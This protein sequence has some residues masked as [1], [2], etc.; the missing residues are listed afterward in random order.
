MDDPVVV[1]SGVR[2][3][4]GRFGGALKDVPAHEL[5]ATC[6]CEALARAGV[7]PG[8]VEEVVMGEVGQVG[9]DAYN[10]RRVAL[11]AGI[12]AGATAMNVNRLCSSGLQA[13]V[14]GAMELLTGQADV[15]VAGGNESMSRLPFLDYHARDGYRLGSHELVDGTLA[16]LTDP[17]GNCLMGVTG[18]RVA[19]RYGVARE[20][21]DRFAARSQQRAQRAIDE[22]RFDEQIVPVTPPR[23]EAPVARDEHPRRDVTVEQLAKLRP[24]FEAGG[25]ATAGNASGI[26]DGAA[27]VVLMRESEA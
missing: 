25:T 8:E 9:P 7:E 2:T 27:A 17:F 21:Q 15:V 20:E 4:I 22:G 24:A 16:L 3:P 23:A 26:N 11:S 18:D 13:I 12:P 6:V 19:E 1:V 5:G 14:T 10:A